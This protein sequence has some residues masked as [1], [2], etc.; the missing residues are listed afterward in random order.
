[1]YERGCLDHRCPFVT[2][3]VANCD[4]VKEVVWISDMLK[5]VR[6]FSAVPMIYSN[7]QS[8]IHLSKKLVYHEH[9]KHIAAKF[10]FIRDMLADDI[11]KFFKIDIVENHADMGTKVVKMGKFQLWQDLLHIF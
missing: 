3:Y 5:E 4:Y 7:N 8:A 6:L 9:T 10:H 11:I 2:V 1:M